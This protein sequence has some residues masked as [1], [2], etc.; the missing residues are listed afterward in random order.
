MYKRLAILIKSNKLKIF[1]DP[2]YGFI[3]IPNGLIFD[4]IATPYF[5]RFFIM[6]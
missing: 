3:T 4:L 5:Q 6:H 2:I 1:N